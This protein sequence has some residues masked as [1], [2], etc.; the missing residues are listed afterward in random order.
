M[1][2]RLHQYIVEHQGKTFDRGIIHHVYKVRT[3]SRRV[4]ETLLA[5]ESGNHRLT[6][7]YAQWPRVANAPDL[8]ETDIYEVKVKLRSVRHQAPYVRAAGAST[9]VTALLI[10][11]NAVTMVR[12]YEQ[13]EDRRRVRRSANA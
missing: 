5:L 2:Q 7:G 3:K 9:A 4:A 12:A 11:V 10:I 1:N 8:P 13:W 6:P